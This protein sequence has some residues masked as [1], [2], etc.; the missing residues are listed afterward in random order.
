MPLIVHWDGE[1]LE[2]LTSKQHMDRLPILI[3]CN[4]LSKLLGVQKLMGGSRENA[5]SAVAAILSDW[6]DAERVKAMCFDKT[7]ANIGHRIGGRAFL[8]SRC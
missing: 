4:G 5:A 3:S 8:S 6:G 7:E 2:E 1:L